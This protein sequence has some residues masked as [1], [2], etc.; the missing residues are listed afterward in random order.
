[1]KVCTHEPSNSLPVSFLNRLESIIM[2]SNKTATCQSAVVVVHIHNPALRRQ[3][4]A[5]LQIWGHPGVQSE[6]QEPEL[7][8]E[9]QPPLKEW[10]QP[11]CHVVS[12]IPELNP[13][14][15]Q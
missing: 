15:I 3:R 14:N 11:W 1:M 7:H 4:Q 12:F 13:Q 6:F 8:W 2:A 10:L 9:D 5:D